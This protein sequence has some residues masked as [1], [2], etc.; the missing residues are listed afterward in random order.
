MI[1]NR[2]L[3]EKKQ[4]QQQNHVKSNIDEIWINLGVDS[5]NSLPVVLHYTYYVVHEPKNSAECCKCIEWVQCGAFSVYEYAD[6]LLSHEALSEVSRTLGLLIF[7]RVRQLDRG[8]QA[9]II[10][11]INQPRHYYLPKKQ[12]EHRLYTS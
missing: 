8:H 12:Q 7:L 6:V 3:I 10:T 9:H 5:N 1:I 2:F 11:L 4:Q